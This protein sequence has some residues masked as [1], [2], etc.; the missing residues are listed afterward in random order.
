MKG[1]TMTQY[2]ATYPYDDGDVLHMDL[3]TRCLSAMIYGAP[4]RLD[5][6]RMAWR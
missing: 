1:D 5:G 4:L 6:A 3:S 2:L